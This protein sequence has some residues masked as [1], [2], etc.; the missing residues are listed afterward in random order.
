MKRN[1]LLE[2]LEAMAIAAVSNA[3]VWAIVL[4]IF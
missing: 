4:A 2:T 1:E 3:I